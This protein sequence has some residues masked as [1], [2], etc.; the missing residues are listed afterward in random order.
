MQQGP[1]MPV[2]HPRRLRAD[3]RGHQ[4]E[5]VTHISNRL[6]V[7]TLKNL[8]KPRW[9]CALIFSF[10]SIHARSNGRSLSLFFISSL[11][12]TTDSPAPSSVAT[13]ISLAASSF[14]LHLAVH[15]AGSRRILGGIS[16]LAG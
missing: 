1:A 15:S 5:A 11:R 8:A 14:D 10:T 9:P 7:A 6:T 13:A 12:N 2:G 16:S 3:P 4:P